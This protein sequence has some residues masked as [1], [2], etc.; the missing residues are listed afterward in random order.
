MDAPSLADRFSIRVKT[1]LYIRPLFGDAISGPSM[2]A[3]SDSSK[4]PW[5]GETVISANVRFGSVAV[6]Q[7]NSSSMTGLGWKAAVRPFFWWLAGV[8]QKRTFR[9]LLVDLH[10]G[11]PQLLHSGLHSGGSKSTGALLARRASPYN[12]EP[13]R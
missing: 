4:G 12:P 11:C 1:R 13:Y 6:I 2:Y 3:H 8:G 10:L 9:D 7:T 5:N